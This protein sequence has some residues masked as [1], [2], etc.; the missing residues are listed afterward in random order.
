MAKSKNHFVCQNCGYITPKWM[1][2][3]PECSRWDSLVEEK[4]HIDVGGDHKRHIM[5]TT[6]KPKSLSKIQII[7]EDRL[8]TGI[9]ELDRVLGGGIVNGMLVLVGGDP[10][11]GK[12]TLLLQ[13]SNIVASKRKKV[14]YVSA[15]E[16]IKQTK[17]RADRLGICEDNVYVLSENNVNEILEQI[18]IIN[19]DVL[20]IDSIQTVFHPDISSAPGSVSQVRESTGVFMRV[21]KG[22]GISTF[23]VGHVTKSGSIAGPKV[24][25]HMVD[26][27]LYFEG[28]QNHMYRILRAVKNRYGSTNEIGVF[29]MA[30]VGLKEV[31]NPSHI[32][33]S[34]RPKNAS[35]SVVIAAIEGTRPMLLELQALVSVSTFGNPRRMANGVDY[36]RVILLMAI[37]EKQ[38]GIMLGNQD[39]YVNVIG[40]MSMDEPAADMAIISAIVSSYKNQQIDENMMIFGE[41]G[42][43]G[44][45]RSVSYAGIRISEAHKLG[46]KRCIIPKGNMDGLEVPNGM[47]IYGVENVK[48]ALAILFHCK[49]I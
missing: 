17:I 38:I 15:E 26:T 16:S 4:A 31:R 35:G 2:K 39:S 12:S 14:L 46:F 24:L 33:L 18:Q 32:F 45:V 10:G 40:G 19:P 9:G 23:L 42:L 13:V 44:E 7:D 1:G 29:E 34:N 30:N 43:T 5:E 22:M 27:V 49:H 36:N 37:L 25:E 11:I 28:E 21:A 20:I 48:E 41:V 6:S 47:K 8:L 3:C